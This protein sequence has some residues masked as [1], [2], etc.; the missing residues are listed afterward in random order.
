[1]RFFWSWKGAPF[2]DD[3]TSSGFNFSNFED[4]SMLLDMLVEKKKYKFP[5]GNIISFSLMLCQQIF[6]TEKAEKDWIV[7]SLILISTTE[8]LI[9]MNELPVIGYPC[10]REELWDRHGANIASRWK[11]M[12]S[13]KLFPS[14]KKKNR[15][16]GEINAI[17]P[18]FYPKW[19]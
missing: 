9:L 2:S 17:S 7:F 5:D 3:K 4:I 10:F 15:F 1:M 18:L 8:M 13:G 16:W 12:Y 14:V 19:F 6:N 11:E